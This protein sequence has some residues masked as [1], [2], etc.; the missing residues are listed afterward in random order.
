[1]NI[2]SINILYHFA[3]QASQNTFNTKYLQI[4]AQQYYLLWIQYEYNNYEIN[5]IFE[6]K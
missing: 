4:Q 6:G 1:M 2:M 5:S 3:I